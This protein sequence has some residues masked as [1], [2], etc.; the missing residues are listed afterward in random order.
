MSEIEYDPS[1]K[2]NLL[3]HVGAKFIIVV[4]RFNVFP[5]AVNT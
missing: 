4:C 2:S 3:F 1:S 5:G